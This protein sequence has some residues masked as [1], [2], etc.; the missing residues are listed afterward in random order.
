MAKTKPCVIEYKRALIY[1]RVSS[2][3]QVNE[4]HGLDS[5][6]AR[7]V[8]RARELGLEVAKVFPDGGVSGGLFERPA[9]N[10]LISYLDEHP[11][12][13]FVIIFDDLKR[14]ARGT[15]VHIMLKTALVKLRGAK[16]ECLNFKF[17]NTPIGRAIETIMS[18][19]AQLEREQGA[20]QVKNKMKARLE[21]GYWTFCPPPGLKNFKDSIKGKILKPVEPFADIYKSAI[22]KYRDY[23]LS[24]LEEVRQFVLSKYAENNINR[25]LALHGVKE[26]LT[27]LLY[28]GYLEYAPWGVER[29]KAQHEGFI[30][31]ETY[32]AVQEHLNA[33]AKP[34]TRKDYS[35]DFPLR[36]F[37]VCLN[38]HNL[39]AAHFKNKRGV[40][41]PYYI[42]KTKGC[43]GSVAKDKM[44]V[45]F[46]KLLKETEPLKEAVKGAE[47]VLSDL[48]NKRKQA[49][50][51]YQ[52]GLR[53]QILDLE[54][55]N[56][57]YLA[58][59]PNATNPSLVGQYENAMA[60]NLVKIEGLKQELA[61][62]KYSQ[63]DFLTALREVLNFIQNPVKE[64][65]NPELGNK[66]LLINMYF[67]K[68]LVYEPEAGF[69]TPE[70]PDIFALI[71]ELDNSK[72]NLVEM[73]G[74]KPG[75]KTCS[76]SNCSQD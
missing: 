9:M 3:R 59:I 22:E 71:E 24:T 54:H 30:S 44:D 47:I 61:K 4:G 72:N 48:W 67:P 16:L 25:P 75:S 6:E 40:K 53:K 29:M 45:D 19:T 55:T 57:G 23:E 70:L 33:S 5:Q 1:C 73:P 13:K 14:L 38:Q 46:I 12:E 42:C 74:V 28:C 68:K 21:A 39:T 37:V 17:E 60:G 35:N 43:I 11:N 58:R 7:C 56:S 31:Y 62:I 52:N 32:L 27:E 50:G 18:A 41:Y 2:E 20:E 69:Q 15:E 49:Q 36:G 76:A 63:D 8:H 26:I 64:W 34:R 10:N 65:E 66:T 51:E